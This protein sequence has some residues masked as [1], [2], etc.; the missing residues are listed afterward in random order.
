[1]SSKRIEFIE[2]DLQKC[3][4]TY[5]VA[6]CTAAVGV[7]GADKCYNC[8][9]TCQDLA[10]IDEAPETVRFSKPS[11][12]VRFDLDASPNITVPN[13]EG[14]SY[15]PPELKL[16]ESIGV[17]ASITVQFK[18]HQSPDTDASGDKYQAER[19]YDAWSQ[20]TYFGKLRA[21]YPSLQGLPL[22]WIV[23]T[24]D[25]LI[26]NMETRHFV[27]D[28]NSGPN[29]AG[30]FTITARDILRLTQGDQSVAPE[31][32]DRST[33]TV[34]GTGSTGFGIATPLNTDPLVTNAPGYIVLAGQEIVSYTTAF[35]GPSNSQIV[36]QTRGEFGTEPVDN[37]AGDVVDFQRVASFPGQS[38]ADILYSLITDYAGIDPTFVPLA[39]WQNEADTYINRNY[40]SNI[41]EPTSVVQLINELLEQTASTMWW[42]NEAQLIRWQVLKQPPQGAAT[43]DD[44]NTLRGSFN[45]SDDYNRRV[46]RCY[47]YF[48]QV[49]PLL[50]LDEK[51]NYAVR[52]LRQEIESEA[53]FDNKAAYKTILSRWIASTSRE[54][55][56]KL[57]DLI[58]QRFSFP[59]RKI[60]F[61][62]LRDSGVTV[63]QLG[64]AYNAANLFLQDETGAA[65][66]IPFQVTGLTPM[67]TDYTVRGEEILFNEVI[68]PDDPNVFNITLDT[69]RT[70]G[71]N[72][73]EI[74]DIESPNPPTVDTVVNVTVAQGVVIG[75]DSA[76]VPSIVSGDWPLGMDPINLVNNGT[77]VGRGGNGGTGGRLQV[78]LGF[79]ASSFSV[80]SS[81]N[82]GNGQPGGDAIEA[83]FDIDL[84]NNG[85]IGGG[86]GGGGGNGAAAGSGGSTATGDDKDSIVFIGGSGGAGGAGSVSGN[87]ASGLSSSYSFTNP[88]YSGNWVEGSPF[89]SVVGGLAGSLEDGGARPAAAGMTFSNAQYSNG[90]VSSGGGVG[91]D[92]GEGGDL[93]QAGKDG[94]DG[95]VN[96]TDFTGG[97]APFVTFR[98]AA[99]TG[100]NGGAAGNAIVQNGGTVNILVA[101]DI[102]GAIV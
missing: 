75:S 61:K 77:I 28:A 78:A 8:R 94:S 5:G 3:Q 21:R 26:A 35:A 6:P 95:V 69:S 50:Q 102:R 42:D 43:F 4:N 60:G 19:S 9:A 25:Q 79:S 90:V 101:G 88:A 51:R 46:S 76:S 27:I 72:I 59:P 73:R 92:G 64:G 86:G 10:N 38:P 12:L 45:I 32:T 39:D 14:I 82:G 98:N 56:E 30:V 99:T 44:N 29:T 91:Q 74:F 48:G 57:G 96:Q 23:G 71:V 47:V 13:I 37:S 67:N 40:G 2:I 1:M 20:G 16:G 65:K 93:G 22:R 55:A 85:L 36:V 41:A 52:V 18:D 83:T 53:F 58:L 66:T 15:A 63:P 11:T 34:F 7:T 70:D 68:A 24:D 17:R 89:G 31:I 97:G 54:T 80:I 87:G 84:T 49:N 62:L 100:G 81:I 33:T